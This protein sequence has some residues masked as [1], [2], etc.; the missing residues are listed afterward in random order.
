MGGRYYFGLLFWYLRLRYTANASLLRG[1]LPSLHAV[2][3]R[4]RLVTGLC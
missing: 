3:L 4:L 2:R 1:G